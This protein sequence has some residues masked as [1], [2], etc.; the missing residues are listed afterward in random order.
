MASKSSPPS[1]NS[2][3]TRTWVLHSKGARRVTMPGWPRRRRRAKISRRT[4]AT[5]RGPLSERFGISL[6][7]ARAPVRT[8]R[9]STAAPNEPAPSVSTSPSAPRQMSYADSKGGDPEDA[10]GKPWRT[11]RGGA[12][13]TASGA[14]SAPE[15]ESSSDR[16]TKP[17]RRRARRVAPAAR[18]AMHARSNIGGGGGSARARGR[19]AE[20]RVH[21]A[22]RA[23][24]D[25]TTIASSRQRF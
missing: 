23:R 4:S 6:H 15:S 3:T 5:S 25:L 18:S 8:S 19:R 16:M 14:S 7:A 1:R 13:A 22:R 11:G 24:D 17:A 20:A 10:S 12:I 21:P 9:T 2:V